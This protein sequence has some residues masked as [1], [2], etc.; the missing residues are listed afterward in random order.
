M[1]RRLEGEAFGVEGLLD[2]SNHVAV[3]DDEDVTVRIGHLEGAMGRAVGDDSY[4]QPLRLPLVVGDVEV[5]HH[6]VPTDGTG[7]D[8][9]GVVSDRQMRPASHL[10]HRKVLSHLDRAHPDPFIEARRHRRV[11]RPQSDVAGP[12]RWTTISGMHHERPYPG[13]RLPDSASTP[14]HLSE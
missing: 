4:R 5:L 6:E 1:R 11:A 13:E 14:T 9:L 10:E 2:R 12:N 8:V 7:P 3:A